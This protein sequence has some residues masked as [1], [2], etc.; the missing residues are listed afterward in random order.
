MSGRV[1]LFDLGGV[2]F[3]FVP[4]RRVTAI[5]AACRLEDE[6]KVRAFLAGPLSGDLDLGL[7]SLGDLAA[8]LAR[9]AEGRIGEDE[10]ADL[11]L[12][13]FQPVG[14]LWRLAAGLAQEN[15]VGVFSDNPPFVRRKFPE[16]I[17]FSH[18]LLS[19]ELEAIK[20]SR[21]AFKAAERA[22]GAPGER[23]VFIDD[24]FGNVMAAR[25]HGWT[26]LHYRG[27]ER[28]MADLRREKLVGETL[29]HV[30]GAP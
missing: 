9:L 13:V 19:S 20:P 29:P 6:D 14:D 30:R 4:A 2:L 28:L 23:I 16:E 24:A 5:A 8:A 25:Q 1:I 10:A 26:A 3:D 27:M 22:V 7:A 18:V 15:E 12:S 17:G 11:W 21:A